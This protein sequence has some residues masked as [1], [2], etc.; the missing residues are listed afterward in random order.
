MLHVFYKKAKW[1]Y[2]IT[3]LNHSYLGRRE[4]C[5]ILGMLAKLF[6]KI[7]VAVTWTGSLYEDSLRRKDKNRQAILALSCFQEE[8]L[9]LDLNSQHST[10]LSLP[11][12]RSMNRAQAIL[13]F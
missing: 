2:G 4:G 13:L 1:I 10:C 3:N 6:Y 9:R 7:W 5:K 8:S 11:D 12:A